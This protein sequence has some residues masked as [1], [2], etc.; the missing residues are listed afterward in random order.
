[1]E[2]AVDFHKS[3]LIKAKVREMQALDPKRTFASCWAELQKK[4]PA[5]F[6]TQP[7]PKRSWHD[8]LLPSADQVNAG[9][10]TPWLDLHQVCKDLRIPIRI[11]ASRAAGAGVLE[12][13]DEHA[14]LLREWWELRGY[15]LVEVI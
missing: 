1:M 14:K 5:L 15:E 2:S 7:E 13:S 10:K 9:V 12:L 6:E 11:E 4:E 8:Q 3:L